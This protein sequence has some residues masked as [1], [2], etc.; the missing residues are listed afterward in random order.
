MLRKRK[1]RI[2][3]EQA[4]LKRSEE[5]SDIMVFVSDCLWSGPPRGRQLGARAGRQGRQRGPTPRMR[6]SRRIG[7]WQVLLP[8]LKWRRYGIAGWKCIRSGARYQG[9]RGHL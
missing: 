9:V 5:E 7:A 1:E 8:Q 3:V 6:K 4:K 2:A